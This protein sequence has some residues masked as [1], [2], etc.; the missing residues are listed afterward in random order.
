MKRAFAVLFLIATFLIAL[1]VFAQEKS[2]KPRYTKTAKLL[3]GEIS[4][5][6]RNFISIIYYK[7]A[8][9]GIEYEMAFPLDSDIQLKHKRSLDQLSVG[10]T[11]AIDF[12]ET[13]EETAGGTDV[14]NKARAIS[15]VRPAVKVPEPP[16]EPEEEVLPIK[17][18][19]D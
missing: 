12:D 13:I 18:I 14:K 1:P 16:D 5:I 6:S 17:G 3:Q 4:G 8:Q 2:D 15:F 9:K 19:R 7:D 10:D 11:V